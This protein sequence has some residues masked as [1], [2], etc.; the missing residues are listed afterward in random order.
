M[1]VKWKYKC[2][3]EPIRIDTCSL[4]WVIVVDDFNR[5]RFLNKNADLMFIIKYSEKKEVF[6]LYHNEKYVAENKNSWF[7]I[8]QIVG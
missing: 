4:N 1:I 8:N 3:L 6:Y 7:F 5:L 2:D